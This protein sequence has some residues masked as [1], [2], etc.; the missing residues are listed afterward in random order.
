MEKPENSIHILIISKDHV[1]NYVQTFADHLRR[2]S[3]EIQKLFARWSEKKFELINIIA[4]YEYKT[5]QYSEQE[6][7]LEKIVAQITHQMAELEI[8]FKDRAEVFYERATSEIQRVV[9]RATLLA[10]HLRSHVDSV[11]TL[12]GLAAQFMDI[13]TL[14]ETPQLFDATFAQTLS[15]HFSEHLAGHTQIVEYTEEAPSVWDEPA[16][17]RLNFLAGKRGKSETHNRSENVLHTD[18]Q[19]IY[20]L[21]GEEL[22][23]EEDYER[24][25]AWFFAQRELQLDTFI[26]KDSEDCLILEEIID[27]CLSH[28][29]NRCSDQAGSTI[30]LLNPSEQRYVHLCTPD[31]VLFYRVI[32]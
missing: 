27:T 28:S 31:G 21:Q 30:V 29:A 1:V 15:L 8:W 20:T 18:M 16:P 22:Q 7:S 6:D 3:D 25:F 24:R 11:T 12:A 26:P 10:L 14:E 9:N 19:Q 23:K 2:I 13:S 32:D 5:Q 17:S 4:Q